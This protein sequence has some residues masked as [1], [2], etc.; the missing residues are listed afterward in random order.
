MLS[1]KD[2][3]DCMGVDT[4]GQVS[5]LGDL[6]GFF[7]RRVPPDPVT[8]VTASVSVKDQLEA[9]TGRH[10]HLNMI[11]VG[12]DTLSASDQQDADDKVDYAVYRTRNIYA[13]V[14]LGVGRV[15]HYAIDADDSNG[16]DDLGSEGEADDLSDEFSIDNDGIDVFLV[17]NISDT[18]FVGISPV[19]G[20]CDKGGDDDGLVGGEIN[21]GFEGFSRTVA[22]EIGH[23]LNLS[24]NHGADC[25][26]TTAGMNNL[27]AQ[28]RCAI[29]TRTSVLLTNA[30]GTTM[31]GRCQTNDGC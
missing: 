17:R 11:T 19:P 20:D 30:Q 4:S 25:P 14:N 8:T 9:M 22:H 6:F 7:Q 18:D 26:T 23:F 10:V 13:Q 1:V 24:H 31:R 3:L 28:T 27:M 12:F 5:V 2:T 21:R 15:E 29:S 16:H